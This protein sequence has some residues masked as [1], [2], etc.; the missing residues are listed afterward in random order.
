MKTV[1]SGGGLSAA[2]V[3]PGAGSW[4]SFRM[5]MAEVCRE[6]L[7][8]GGGFFPGNGANVVNPFAGSLVTAIDL[9]GQRLVQGKQ[10]LP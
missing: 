10:E 5:G 8:S 6:D 7:N 3:F 1:R 4:H 9:G 2:D